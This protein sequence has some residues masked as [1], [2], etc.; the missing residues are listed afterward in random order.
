MV[1]V[2]H[3]VQKGVYRRPRK[4]SAF[5]TLFEYTFCL[6]PIHSYNAIH[7]PIIQMVSIATMTEGALDVL[8]CGTFI[9]L[10][11]NGLP[12]DVNGFIVLFALL[13]LVNG[14]Q[15]FALQCIL[16]GGHDDT[17]LDLVR[18]NGF[19]RLARVIIDAGSI[20]LRI[21]LWVKYN[22]VSSVFLV[23]NLYNLIHT[24][25]HVERWSGI[26]RYPKDTLFTEFVSPQ[27]WY[28]L[29]KEEWRKATSETV[30]AQ[31]RSGRRV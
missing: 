2:L 24:T 29:T 5:T 12:S 19:F 13:E 7:D 28:G 27:D 9:A 18:W 1:V 6:T 3:A 23:K 31:A 26:S 14:A 30:V 17:P 20:L 4:V 8:S 21:I 16:S 22:A 10:A 11:A 15:S 25:S